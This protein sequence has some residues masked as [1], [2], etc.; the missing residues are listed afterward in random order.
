MV[1]RWVSCQQ[2]IQ[3]GELIRG[4]K[5]HIVMRWRPDIRPLTPFPPLSD[6]VWAAVV[7]STVIVPG[8]LRY[9]G[10]SAAQ[11]P[12]EALSIVSVLQLSDLSLT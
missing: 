1:Q 6:P 7:P 4:R 2:L 3:T 10:S 11:V 8:Y 12:A 9:F 5:Y